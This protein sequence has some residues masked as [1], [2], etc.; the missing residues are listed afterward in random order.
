MSALFKERK[1][2]Q[3]ESFAFT[4][5]N[6]QKA[7]EII[8]RYPASNQQSAVM[9]LLHLAARQHNGWIPTAAM[10]CIAEILQ[11]P[12]IKVY[13]VANFYTMYN[14][15]PVGK[16]LVQVC[17]TIP[18]WLRGA[19]D[20]TEAC[21]NHLKIDLGETTADEEFTL[22]EVECL[23]AC[24]N[25]PMVQINDDYYEDLTPEAMTEILKNLK[26]GKSVNVGS[27]IGRQTSAPFEADHGND[28]STK[29]PSNK[30][31]K[32]PTKG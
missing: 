20:I 28:C 6:M 18:C 7:K 32:I 5:E 21:K 8:A 15:Q 10:D 22:I 25:A 16:H 13:E 27:Q 23:G 19:A 12:N 9:P 11:M 2:Q 29:A 31:K 17:R 14:K 1:F 4:P 30:K 24:V 26:N 3:P